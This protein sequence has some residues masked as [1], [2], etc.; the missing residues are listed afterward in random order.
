MTLFEALK[1]GG[2]AA[3]P[4]HREQVFVEH[5]GTLAWT[6]DGT[7][8]ISLRIDDFLAT[9]WERFEIEEEDNILEFRKK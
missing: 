6:G 4:H 8:A 3:R 5:D 9:D 2:Y 1:N 7:Y